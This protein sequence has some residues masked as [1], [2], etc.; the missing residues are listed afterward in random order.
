VD[1]RILRK[2]PCLAKGPLGRGRAVI[3]EMNMLS[4]KIGFQIFAVVFFFSSIALMTHFVAKTIL[5]RRRKAG[6]NQSPVAMRTARAFSPID[7]LHSASFSLEHADVDYRELEH[8]SAETLRLDAVM[9]ADLRVA[10]A[11]KRCEMGLDELTAVAPET[12]PNPELSARILEGIFNFMKKKVRF[13]AW[14]RVLHACKEPEALGQIYQ[15][16]FEFVVHT[17]PRDIEENMGQYEAFDLTD[18][19]LAVIKVVKSTP[20]FTDLAL[21]NIFKFQLVDFELI[22]APSDMLRLT[23]S[24]R[25]FHQVAYYLSLLGFACAF[26]SEGEPEVYIMRSLERDS[27]RA[28]ALLRFDFD[29][30]CRMT[31]SRKAFEISQRQDVDFKAFGLVPESVKAAALVSFQDQDGL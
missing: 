18:K 11:V 21:N 9:P 19:L 3:T 22:T 6:K 25:R 31:A 2:R 23:D 27:Y 15:E 7:S 17:L 16:A 5:V 29:I 12:F 14:L 28:L 24:L 26:V 13:T 4:H 30:W 20:K 1:C 10:R 8:V